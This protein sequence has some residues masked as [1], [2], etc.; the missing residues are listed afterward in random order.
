VTMV[1]VWVAEVGDGPPRGNVSSQ[2]GTACERDADQSTWDERVGKV[3]SD[4]R[5]AASASTGAR[6]F[7]R[8]PAA[9]VFWLFSIT[10]CPESVMAAARGIQRHPRRSKMRHGNPR[11]GIN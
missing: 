1:A 5:V 6:L 7:L 4:Q 11:G 10:L 2:V 3:G 9:P 8:H